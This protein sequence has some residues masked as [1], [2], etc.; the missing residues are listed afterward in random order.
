MLEVVEGAEVLFPSVVD[1]VEE[2]GFLEGDEYGAAFCLVGF[3]EREAYLVDAP[4][5]GDGYEDVLVHLSFGLV[6]VFDDGVGYG[7]EA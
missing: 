3:F 7:G 6:D 4:S 5:V 1:G 2:D